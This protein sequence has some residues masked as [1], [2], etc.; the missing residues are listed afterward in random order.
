MVLHKVFSSL[1]T[2]IFSSNLN[3]NCSKCNVTGV[4][5][6]D[7]FNGTEAAAAPL[8]NAAVAE[9]EMDDEDANISLDLPNARLHL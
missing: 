8:P 5:T 3:L 6:P 2:V 9:I 4:K 7:S 1:E